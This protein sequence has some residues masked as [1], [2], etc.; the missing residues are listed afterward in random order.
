MKDILI[1]I[2]SLY[3]LGFWGSLFFTAFDIVYAVFWP[4][5]FFIEAYKR[6]KKELS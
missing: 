3:I 1:A 2:S 4:I 6:I 5:F